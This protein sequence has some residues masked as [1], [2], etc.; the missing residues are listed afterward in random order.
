MLN[1]IQKEKNKKDIKKKRILIFCGISLVILFFAY[2]ALIYFLVSASLVPSFMDKLDAFEELT[3]Y[4]YAQQVQS[5]DIKENRSSAIS[6]MHKWLEQTE[7]HKLYRMSNDG[8]QFV[9]SYFLQEEESH[10]WALMLHGY[11]GWKEEMFFYGRWYYEEGYNIMAP[12]QR[13]SGESEGD[14]IGMGYPDHFDCMIWVNE[15]LEMDPE[16]EIVLHGQS[17]GSATALMMAGED[18]P[19]NVKAVVADCA[20]SDAMSMFNAKSEEWFGLP[21]WFVVPSCRIMLLLRGGYDLAKASPIEAVK[22]SH[23]PILFIH[24]SE[25]AMMPASMS[26]EMYKVANCE[27]EILIVEGAGHA[28]A[29]DKDPEAYYGTIKQFIEKYIND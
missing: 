7:N 22:H 28:Q 20:Y 15:I 1:K 14:F 17:M 4:N 12:D 6:D 19:D 18:L 8:Y 23:L 16:A 21:A 24:G 29:Q 3:T 11:T 5:S 10:K 2:W 27:K 26:E 9:A 13:C 25:D